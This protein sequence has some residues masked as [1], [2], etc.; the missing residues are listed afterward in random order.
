[1]LCVC[2]CAYMQHTYNTIHMHSYP[3]LILCINT[4][5]LSAAQIQNLRL[6][7]E[8][9]D[10]KTASGT[11]HTHTCVSLCVICVCS[12]TRE[13]KRGRERGRERDANVRTHRCALVFR[14]YLSGTN[15]HTVTIS[16]TA[17]DCRRSIS[18]LK[19][20]ETRLKGEERR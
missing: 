4:E 5:G 17:G 15:I 8:Q 16:R 6:I 18:T 2:W 13:R 12:C 20:L 7:P 1:V 19:S 14:M 11:V 9:L 3:Q 10:E